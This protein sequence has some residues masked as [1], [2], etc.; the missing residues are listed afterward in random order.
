MS[1]S[2]FHS[3][4]ISKLLFLCCLSLSTFSIKAQEVVRLT[5]P[6]F[7]DSPRKGV[8]DPLTGFRSSAIKGWF[9]CGSVLFPDASPPDIHQGSTD[10]WDNELGTAHGKTYITLVV[11]EDDTYETISQKVMGTLKQGKC[12]TFSIDLAKSKIY[13]SHTKGNQLYKTN[14]SQPAV[15]RLWGGN[16]HCDQGELLA[17][18]EPVS[19]VD[20]KNVSFLIEPNGN[21]SYITVE[22]FFK[23]PILFGYNGNVCMDNASHFK[24]IECGSD[25]LAVS[26]KRE[27]N[28]K[29][30]K[31]LPSFKKKQQEAKVWKKES[32]EKKVDT[33]VYQRPKKLLAD[34][35]RKTLKVGQ[36]IKIDY[37][38]F[39][40]DTSSINVQSFEVLNEVFNF[41]SDNPD[42]KIEIGG[43]TNGAPPSHAYCDKL[44]TARAEAVANYLIHKGIDENR[45][46]F[47]GY[48][49]RRP[50][51]SNGTAEGRKK[52]QRVQIKIISLG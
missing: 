23:T 1:V 27:T 6:S 39:E 15:M 10:F 44:S 13:M 26:E 7:E 19:N 41:L 46:S 8:Y 9:D 29:K 43:H 18:S 21:Y 11:R 35:N 36:K 16:S 38:Y 40:A 5:N 52:N 49:K 32:R 51:F 22:A 28:E 24:L 25:P 20:W 17:E 45:I 47:K 48:G 33:V 3:N 12:Y 37:L 31:V 30:K 14:F 4:I 2:N 34:L 50:L 42:V